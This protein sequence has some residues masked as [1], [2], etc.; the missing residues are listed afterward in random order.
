MERK[1]NHSVILKRIHIIIMYVYSYHHINSEKKRFASPPLLS[2]G[3]P[4]GGCLGCPRERER[5]REWVGGWVFASY[6]IG[7][8]LNWYACYYMLYIIK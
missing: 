5:E 2:W 7:S 6:S 1:V 4:T 8:C 3:K